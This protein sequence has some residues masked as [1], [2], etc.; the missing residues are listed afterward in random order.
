VERSADWTSLLDGFTRRNCGRCARLDV[1][2]P[3]IGPLVQQ[4][5][6]AFLGA[7]YDTHDRRVALML[8]DPAGGTHHLTRSIPRVRDVA[9]YAG[10][11]GHERA[12]RVLAGRSR[13]LLTFVE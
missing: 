2:D 9:F 13:T 10:P 11:G 8:G 7:A 5:G 12:L 4:T 1:D 6:L 3:A